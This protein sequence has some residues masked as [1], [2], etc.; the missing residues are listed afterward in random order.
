MKGARRTEKGGSEGSSEDGP[1]AL[2]GTRKMDWM[3]GGAGVGAQST[4][5]G[6]RGAQRMDGGK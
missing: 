6:V 3:G 2:R 1:G 5:G 4:D